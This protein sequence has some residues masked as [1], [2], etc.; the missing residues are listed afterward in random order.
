M[1]QRKSAKPA[2]QAKQVTIMVNGQVAGTIP[3]EG[4]ILSA[5]SA[6]AQAH[7]LKTYSLR[8]NGKPAKQ[9]DANKSLSGVSTLE[10]FAKDTRG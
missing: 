3:A 10:V 7:G 5:A 2:R 8:I 9:P 4:T 1:A 6:A